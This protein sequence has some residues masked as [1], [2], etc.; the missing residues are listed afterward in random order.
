MLGRR[1]GARNRCS[2]KESEGELVLVLGKLFVQDWSEASRNCANIHA[3]GGHYFEIGVSGHIFRQKWRP[4]AR[5]DETYL[6][7]APPCLRGPENLRFP[8]KVFIF[9]N[10]EYVR[11]ADWSTSPQHWSRSPEIGKT[12]LQT[13]P[14]SRPHLSTSLQHRPSSPEIGRIRCNIGPLRPKL[15][16]ITPELA[17]IARH[18][19]QSLQ[20][21]PS[22]ADH[23]KHR[24][25]TGRFRP[26]LAELAPESPEF[27]RSWSRLPPNR[28]T[29]AQKWLN[30]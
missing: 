28:V 2:L 15:P 29:F 12:S 4:P 24:K 20:L 5:R 10:H 1:Q 7:M 30:S 8:K 16:D 22:S 18:G 27:A 26:Q 21:W 9:R 3:Q 13:W 25:S 6:A 19:P 14:I 23:G 17:D 11:H